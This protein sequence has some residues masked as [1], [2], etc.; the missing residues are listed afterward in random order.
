MPI[1]PSLPDHGYFSGRTVF[2][3]MQQGNDGVGR[4]VH[5]AQG[6]ARFIQHITQPQADL[7]QMWC[8]ALEVVG[9]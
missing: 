9:R 2:R 3:D 6:I 8:K 1:K 4:E 5:V 7:L